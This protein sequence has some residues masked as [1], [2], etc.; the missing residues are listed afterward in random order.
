MKRR[1]LP[2]P[3]ILLICMMTNAQ[4]YTRDAGARVGDYFTA[5]C[6][7]FTS[8][9]EAL[10]GQLFIGGQGFTVTIMKE[11][12]EPALGN[13]S[14]NLYLQYG[15]GAH[16]GLRRT[17]HYQVFNRTYRL[18]DETISPLLG[19]DGLIGIEYR[20]P[21]FPFLIGFDFK[22]YFEFSTLQIFSIY[23]QS[24]GMSIKYRF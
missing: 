13:L 14:D 22:P 12:F 8:E 4:N 23:L 16:I 20:F 5:T 2:I 6:R 1:I 10:E 24:F 7:Q 9:Y 21:E 18:D 17:D 11:H 3:A 19:V 15:Y